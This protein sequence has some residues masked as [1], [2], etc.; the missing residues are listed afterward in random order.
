MDGRMDG[1]TDECLVY[2]Y[3]DASTCMLC[4]YVTVFLNISNLKF[5]CSCGIG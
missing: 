5:A 2:D 3:V 4:R 1:R